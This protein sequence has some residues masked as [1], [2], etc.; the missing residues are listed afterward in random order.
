MRDPVAALIAD[1]IIRTGAHRDRI[2]ERGWA[3]LK[4]VVEPIRIVA[5]GAANALTC[6]ARARL[7]VRLATNLDRADRH[8]RSVELLLSPAR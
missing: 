3:A 7:S 5:A 1:G 8:V 4:Q 6:V 2:P